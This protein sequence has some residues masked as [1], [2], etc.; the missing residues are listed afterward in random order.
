MQLGGGLHSPE[1]EDQS[2]SRGDRSQLAQIGETHTAGL[3]SLAQ[4]GLDAWAVCQLSCCQPLPG[5]RWAF[6][7]KWPLLAEVTPALGWEPAGPGFCYLE[8]YHSFEPRELG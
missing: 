4:H 6:P 3:P 5:L 2:Y 1:K 8:L 7:G